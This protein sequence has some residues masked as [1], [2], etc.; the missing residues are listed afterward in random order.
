M[1]SRDDVPG[2][3]SI[4]IL[5]LAAGAVVTLLFAPKSGEE[6]RSDLAELLSETANRVNTTRKSF[7]RRGKALVN[8]AKDKVQDAVEAG[9][10]AYRQAKKS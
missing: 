8:L 1:S 4:F 5:G 10:E 2:N 9:N 7:K 6:F 3:I